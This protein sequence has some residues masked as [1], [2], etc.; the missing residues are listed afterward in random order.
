MAP[1]TTAATKAPV[2]VS[3]TAFKAP[4]AVSATASK[5]PAAVSASVTATSS[6]SWSSWEDDA[7]L[8]EALAT[9]EGEGIYINEVL[10]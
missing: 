3:A 1:P 2:A 10:N 5:A 6:S 9:F 8:L 4:S 7:V